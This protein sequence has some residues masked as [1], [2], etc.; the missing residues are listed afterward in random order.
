M[1]P[2]NKVHVFVNKANSV[3]VKKLSTSI[4]EFFHS[5]VVST[6]VYFRKEPLVRGT[7]GFSVLRFWLFF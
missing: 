3:I 1:D 2:C 5:L 6:I 4:S 7:L